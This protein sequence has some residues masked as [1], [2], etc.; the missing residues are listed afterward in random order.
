[1]SHRVRILRTGKIVTLVHIDDYSIAVEWAYETLKLQR[2][3]DGDGMWVATLE[4]GSLLWD[5]LCMSPDI[6][7]PD[8]C[9]KEGLVLDKRILYDPKIDKQTLF[10]LT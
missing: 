10:G 3:L 8:G 5:P 1:V 9:L 7:I 2:A 6:F 4:T